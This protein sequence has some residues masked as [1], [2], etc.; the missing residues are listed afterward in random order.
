MLNKNFCRQCQSGFT[1]VEL[2]VV[3]AIIGV[4]SAVGTQA[5]IGFTSVAKSKA[6]EA[7]FHNVKN[8]IIAEIS[9]CSMGGA[10]SVVDGMSAAPNCSAGLPPVSSLNMHFNRYF[11]SPS[12]G[13]KNPY[14]PMRGALFH[15]ATGARLVTHGTNGSILIGWNSGPD[16]INVYGYPKDNARLSHVIFID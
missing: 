2:L 16:R 5:F 3:I 15:P 14:H 12:A 8:F 7:N 6:S 10:L 13:L 11:G 1:L 9:K 4:L